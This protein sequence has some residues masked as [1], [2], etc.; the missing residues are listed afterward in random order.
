VWAPPGPTAAATAALPAS[1]APP[2]AQEHA[3]AALQ[4][5][6]P[7]LVRR[8]AWE[9]DGQRGAMRLELG[10]GS[11]SGAT[12]LL[13]C[14]GGRVHVSLS[15]PSGSNLDAWRA[16]IGARLAAAGLDVDPVE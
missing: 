3:S 7:L 5:L 13:R 9:G 14:D 11:L 8:V 4:E 15:D 6:W 12:L 10:A 16:R 2:S 1:A